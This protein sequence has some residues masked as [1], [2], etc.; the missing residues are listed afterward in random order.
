M[1][2]ILNNNASQNIL[3]KEGID[4]ILNSI[5]KMTEKNNICLTMIVKDDLDSNESHV[6]KRC[7][8]SCE[9]ILSHAA[10]V[11]TRSDGSNG[12]GTKDIITQWARKK[13]INLITKD[14]EWENDYAKARNI[15]LAMAESTG[16][17]WFLIID[18]DEYIGGDLQYITHG[19]RL[20]N[21]NALVI[22]MFLNGQMQ[23][24]ISLIRNVSGW[25]YFGR[26]HETIKFNGQKPSA[27]IING[28]Q[29]VTESDGAT[30]HD[31]NRI[32]KIID[33]LKNEWEETRNPRSLLFLAE[34]FR[35]INN[36]QDS[37][38]Y[39]EEFIKYPPHD[40]ITQGMKYYGYV[41]AGRCAYTLGNAQYALALWLTA[42]DMCPTRVEALG[43]CALA[44]ANAG[45]WSMA[46]VYALAAA[47][48]PKTTCYEYL[49]QHWAQWKAL[50]ILT[51]A[52]T[53]LNQPEIAKEYYA[54]LFNRA[55]IEELNRIR[56]NHAN[57]VK[58]FMEASL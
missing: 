6:I 48:A 41:G 47:H 42:Y 25:E 58:G 35:L 2:S 23:N 28:V 24:R 46:R 37:L 14:I 33:T 53:K 29:L 52:L 15:S 27:E 49:E 20:T 5:S 16:A 3:N 34:Q 44:H 4:D 39:F 1:A 43:E 40:D 21:Q 7:I 54:L 32:Q 8:K 11:F 9:S 31:P 18:A 30:H 36:Y 22:P 13:D 17:K 55:P 50:D 19:V 45:K 56:S 12:G 51:V 57:M 26:Y 10:I 38:Y